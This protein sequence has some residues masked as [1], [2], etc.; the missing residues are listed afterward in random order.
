MGLPVGVLSLSYFSKRGDP[1]F[2][3]IVEVI[4]PSF[5]IVN[6]CSCTRYCLEL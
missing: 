5:E 3:E 1:L 6:R 2:G 4:A